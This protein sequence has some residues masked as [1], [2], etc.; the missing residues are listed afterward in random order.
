MSEQPLYFAVI[1]VF[2]FG[3]C[4]GSFLNVCIHRIPKKQSIVRPPSACPSCK[5]RIP[6]YY[7]VPILSYIVLKG[8]C[9]FCGHRISPRYP[10]VEALTGF[11]AAAVYIK[12]GLSYETAFWFV[13]IAALITISFIDLDY[14]IIP[15]ILS[16]PGIVIFAAGALF[17]PEMN[18]K[19]SFLGIL[20]GGGTLYLIALAYY[21]VKRREGMG[22]GDIKLLA[23]TG[24]ATGWKGV[25]VTLFA[26]S[27][28]GTAAGIV[29]MV[30]TRSSDSKLKIP[31]G[32]YISL[33]AVIYIFFGKALINWY[34]T[35]V[36]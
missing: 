5:R 8:A 10:I 7:N 4:V 9:C 1:T 18:I 21:A 17:L 25:A 29:V 30:C 3:A 20:A 31:F 16:L 24:A 22:G 19:K 2:I 6:F 32:P 23:M 13:F 28:L 15:D 11:I 36:P 27:L 12:F 14:Q 34:L 26:G 35:G 33:G